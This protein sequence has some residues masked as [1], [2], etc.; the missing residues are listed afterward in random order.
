MQKKDR[1]IQAPQ[2]GIAQHG[3][4]QAALRADICVLLRRGVGHAQGQNQHADQ[5]KHRGQPEHGLQPAPGRQQRT[6]DQGQSKGQADT[7]ADHRHRFGALF[8]RGQIRRQR[9]NRTRYGSGA[10]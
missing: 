9:H 5:R 10:L 1:A 4:E 8:G 2:H 6:A 3:A 7:D